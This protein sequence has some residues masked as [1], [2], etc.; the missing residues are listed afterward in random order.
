M[1]FR[2]FSYPYF[3]LNF[4]RNQIYVGI[5]V[6]N[7]LNTVNN[8]TLCV[9]NV[10]LIRIMLFIIFSE[11]KMVSKMAVSFKFLAVMF[12]EFVFLVTLGYAS[13]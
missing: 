8:I 12:T 4:L 1:Y 6:K 11:N 7:G 5:S 10:I 3:E 9:H 13:L 2:S